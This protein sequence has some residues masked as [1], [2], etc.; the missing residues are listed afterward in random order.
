[1][2]LQHSNIRVS[3]LDGRKRNVILICP[4]SS[5]RCWKRNAFSLYKI[6]VW[7]SC[8]TPTDHS[9][10]PPLLAGYSLCSN[11]F[12]L[13]PQN[14]YFL[15]SVATPDR[16]STYQSSRC[17]DSCLGQ[18]PSCSVSAMHFM[19]SWISDNTLFTRIFFL[20]LFTR[21][22]HFIQ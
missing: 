4:N 21:T 14:C 19:C 12:I 20:S 18:P 11:S 15:P 3:Q 2:S 5:R 16:L 17:N 6:F 7:K 22:S 8:S 9:H 10:E 13:P 1:M